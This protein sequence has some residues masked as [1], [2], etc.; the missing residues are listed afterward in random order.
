MLLQKH[1]LCFDH[2]YTYWSRKELS[3]GCALGNAGASGAWQVQLAAG[4]QLLQAVRGWVGNREPRVALQKHLSKTQ[5]QT[6]PNPNP[7]TQN[8]EHESFSMQRAQGIWADGLLC[9]GHTSSSQSQKKVAFRHSGT[10]DVNWLPLRC[11]PRL[12]WNAVEYLGHHPIRSSDLAK[13][14][15]SW[16]S[17]QL[18]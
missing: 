9:R 6:R 13:Q 17:Q 4:S 16:S 12:L 10:S 3:T 11:R 8:A 5:A 2:S 15:S 18:H 14:A 7:K 1:D